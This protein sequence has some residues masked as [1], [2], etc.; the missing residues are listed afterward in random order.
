MRGRIWRILRTSEWGMRAHRLLRERCGVGSIEFAFIAPILIVAYLGAFEA[1][2]GFSVSRKVARAAATISDLLSQTSVI[3]VETLDSMPHVVRSLM[4]PY[5]AKNFT[6]KVAGIAVD[7]NGQG[8]VS[9]SRDEVG[10]TPFPKGSPIGVPQDGSM[11]GSFV[12]RTELSLPYRMV[13]LDMIRKQGQAGAFSIS[14]T[15]YYRE[16][17]GAEITCS[18]CP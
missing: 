8:K 5:G 9:W 1:S 2:V 17:I 11:N 15:Y 13:M 16:R 6:M 14:K 12:V 7:A 3:S 10:G 18:N 4:A